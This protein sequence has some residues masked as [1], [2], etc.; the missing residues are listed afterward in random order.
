[1]FSSV[2]HRC[3]EPIVVTSKKMKLLEMSAEKTAEALDTLVGEG[4]RIK[5]V[6]SFCMLR[7][8]S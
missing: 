2:E 7:L 4:E 6:V 1:M 8:D 5:L 3:H